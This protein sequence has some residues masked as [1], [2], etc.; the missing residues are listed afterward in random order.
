MR[1][2]AALD[3][4]R[5]R[6]EAVQRAQ[7][8]VAAVAQATAVLLG[9]V[10]SMDGE[11][12][13]LVQ[14]LQG[15]SRPAGGRS[16]LGGYQHGRALRRRE[17]PPAGDGLTPASHARAQR[18]GPRTSSGAAAC[19]R[20]RSSQPRRPRRSYRLAVACRAAATVPRRLRQSRQGSPCSAVPPAAARGPRRRPPRPRAS[21]TAGRRQA[22]QTSTGRGSLRAQHG[23]QRRV[24]Q[25]G[26]SLP[27]GE[28]PAG[29]PG[30]SCSTRSTRQSRSERP[31][32]AA[33]PTTM[34][35]Q[36]I[37]APVAQWSTATYGVPK[38]SGLSSRRSRVRFPPGA[39]AE[40]LVG[41]RG[42]G[43][44]GGSY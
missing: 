37:H 31:T 10:E 18:R 9:R 14:S 15:R 4:E 25:R 16:C 32:P 42:L 23:A 2:E 30:G 20:V 36:A 12:G 8:H 7:A 21:Q 1:E 40:S 22:A 6:A 34:R 3:A 13:A 43:D 41:M 17:R 24:A 29:R 19:P 5:T 11:V 28:L 44:G 33:H 39:L 27:E 26:R 38:S 35:A